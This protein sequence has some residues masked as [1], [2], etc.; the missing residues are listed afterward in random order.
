MYDD[1]IELISMEIA[2]VHAVQSPQRRHAR[3]AERVVSATHQVFAT[4]WRRQILIRRREQAG[5]EETYFLERVQHRRCRLKRDTQSLRTKICGGTSRSHPSLPASILHCARS[6]SSGY[7]K[8][9]RSSQAA[10]TV[11]TVALRVFVGICHLFGLSR[12]QR[13][14][15]HSRS[16]LQ[17]NSKV[18]KQ[19]STCTE[20]VTNKDETGVKQN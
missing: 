20:P 19:T 16:C 10:G 9:R 14:S 15:L 3:E 1:S 8:R 5:T 11:C 13:L 2:A 18:L 12:L 4:G 17:P 7:M 6:T